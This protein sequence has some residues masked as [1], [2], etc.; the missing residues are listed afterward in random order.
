MFLLTDKHFGFEMALN[1]HDTSPLKKLLN[2]DKM[3]YG[4]D[5]S[6]GEYMTEQGHSINRPMT[7]LSIAG[8]SDAEPYVRAREDEGKLLSIFFCLFFF[9]HFLHLELVSR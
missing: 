6:I 7:R 1:S 8:T 2:S 5:L 3:I 9:L 4:F